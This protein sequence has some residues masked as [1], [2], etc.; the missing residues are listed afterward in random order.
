MGRR[1]TTRLL[2][3]IKCKADSAAV[4]ALSVG[5]NRA[6]RDLRGAF[7]YLICFFTELLL[8]APTHLRVIK[9]FSWG[10]RGADCQ[11]FKPPVSTYVVSLA[12]HDYSQ[13]FFMF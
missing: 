9:L 3:M 8:C 6:V 12:R 4:A 7:F 13:Y 5:A 2:V 10:L 11:S 1:D